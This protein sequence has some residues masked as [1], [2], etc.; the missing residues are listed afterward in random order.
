MP[1]H[2]FGRCDGHHRMVDCIRVPSLGL[3]S[4][5]EP[6]SA[7]LCS[8]HGV[9]LFLDDPGQGRARLRLFREGQK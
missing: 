3:T 4:F 1:L 8:G 2:G 9:E 7:R 6:R 5:P